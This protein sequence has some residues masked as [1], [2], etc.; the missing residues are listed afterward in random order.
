M[1]N[2]YLEKIK[3]IDKA[4]VDKLVNAADVFKKVEADQVVNAAKAFVEDKIDEVHPMPKML[5]GKKVGLALAALGTIGAA[6]YGYN[7]Y[8]AKHPAST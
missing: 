1:T 7:K 3:S 8:L 5:R 2:K 4:D 6:G